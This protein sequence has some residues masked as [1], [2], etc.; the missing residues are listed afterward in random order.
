MTDIVVFQSQTVKKKPSNSDVK[1]A[2]WSKY[3]TTIVK[4]SILVEEKNIKR[5]DKSDL[6]GPTCEIFSSTVPPSSQIQ[7]QYCGSRKRK[8]IVYNLRKDHWGEGGRIQP[9]RTNTDLLY[10]SKNSVLNW[11]KYTQEKSIIYNIQWLRFDS[12]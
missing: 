12:I 4:I 8:T 3:K 1:Y 10:L 7:T 9:I 11:G 2:F 6:K 5:K